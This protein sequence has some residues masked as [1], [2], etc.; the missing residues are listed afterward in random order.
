[1]MANLLREI[2]MAARVKALPGCDGSRA[3]LARGSAY[4]ITLSCRGRP[5]RSPDEA[6]RNPGVHRLDRA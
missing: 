3:V 4:F 2:D 5:A 6:K 1:M